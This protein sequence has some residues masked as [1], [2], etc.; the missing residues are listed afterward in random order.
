M[1]DAD[2]SMNTLVPNPEPTRMTLIERLKQW[3]DH[4]SWRDFFDSYWKLIYAFAL[5]SGLRPDEAEEVVQETVISVSRNIGKFKADSAFGSFKSW[6]MQLARWR[7]N[8]QL[9]KRV[10]EGSD[11]V[12]LPRGGTQEGEEVPAVEQIP[13]SSA[14]GLDAVWEEEWQKNILE[15][16][17]AR[18]RRR[19]SARHYQIF[20]THVIDGTSASMTARML[21]TSVAQ[22]YL[23]KHRLSRMLKKAAREAEADEG[24]A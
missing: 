10:R 17:L 6:L 15:A 1:S 22:V 7:I 23:V 13:D 5:R 24:F 20:H 11:R 8:D 9:R 4:E 14:N 16:A 3:D 21:G 19:V 12:N 2:S 18:L